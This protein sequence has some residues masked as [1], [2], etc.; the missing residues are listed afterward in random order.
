[1]T[2]RG[3]WVRLLDNQCG[4]L[5]ID[6]PERNIGWYDGERRKFDHPSNSVCL[7]V[8]NLGRF[9]DHA[10]EFSDLL[11]Q[12]VKTTFWVAILIY[13][14]K[15]VSNVDHLTRHATEVQLGDIRQVA[16]VDDIE[17]VCIRIVRLRVFPKYDVLE[18][19]GA[20]GRAGYATLVGIVF[21]A[22]R[23]WWRRV[24]VSG[25]LCVRRSIIWGVLALVLLRGCS[26][27][28]CHRVEVDFGIFR[29]DREK[30]TLCEPRE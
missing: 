16:I 6:R 24:D 8:A 4:S 12:R 13:I 20:C 29:G 7:V 2:V 14:L 17:I 18:W 21:I 25:R 22:M 11:N 5:A 15:F 1:M 27:C 10:V 28:F 3:D 19:C 26:H 23:R 30:F 9:H